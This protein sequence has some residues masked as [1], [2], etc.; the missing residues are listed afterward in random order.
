MTLNKIFIYIIVAITVL[1]AGI[2]YSRGYTTAYFLGLAAF[3]V[4]WLGFG[5]YAHKTRNRFEVA[6]GINYFTDS[7]GHAA[8]AIIGSF[9]GILLRIW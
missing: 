8:I 6:A 1:G 5:A 2:C 9:I 3:F 7:L 4:A